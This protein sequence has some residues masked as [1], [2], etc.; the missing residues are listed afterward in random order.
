MEQSTITINVKLGEDKIP[1]QIEWKAIGTTAQQVQQ[2]KAFMLA[3]WDGAEKTA[4]RIDLWTKEMMVDEMADFF[5]Q[6]FITMAETYNR[7][8][9][10]D[11]LAADMKEF[12]K[13]FYNKFREKYLK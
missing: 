6:T 1:Q 10:H 8:T 11:E 3:F 9:H 5:Y 2:A 4:L 12:A 7:A 13:T